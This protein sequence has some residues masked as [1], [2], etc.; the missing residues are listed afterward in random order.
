MLRLAFRQQRWTLLAFC[1]GIALLGYLNSRAFVL[2]AGSTPAE[3]AQ[4]GREMAAIAAQ[5]TVIT[6]PP[7]E[8][9]T[10]AGWVQWR[11]YGA[12]VPLLL[13]IWALLAGS[14]LRADEE[15]GLVET[16]LAGGS[17]KLGLVA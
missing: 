14:G 8:V 13:P 1:F 6:P 4:F 15:K 11:F 5:F 17:T 9:G 16:W 2:T 7:I 10:M 3:Q 12:Q